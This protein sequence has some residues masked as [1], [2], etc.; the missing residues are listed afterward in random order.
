MAD[1]TVADQLA[2]KLLVTT[3]VNQQTLSLLSFLVRKATYSWKSKHCLFSGQ[4][5]KWR[6]GRT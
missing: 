2:Q 6:G 4:K 5:Q 3:E 1:T